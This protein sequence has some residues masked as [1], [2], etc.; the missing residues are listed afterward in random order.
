MA[1]P[2]YITISKATSDK[3]KE[4]TDSLTEAIEKMNTRTVRA[5]N[6]K[7]H[8]YGLDTPLSEQHLDSEKR[9]FNPK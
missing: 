2:K 1:A 3:M 4:C 9:H 6:S 5:V 7:I 8:I